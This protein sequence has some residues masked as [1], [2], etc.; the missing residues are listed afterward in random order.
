MSIL[1]PSSRP[2]QF[3]YKPRY[4]DKVNPEWSDEEK[5]IRKRDYVELDFKWKK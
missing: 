3:E 4:T 1:F 5:T 2:K